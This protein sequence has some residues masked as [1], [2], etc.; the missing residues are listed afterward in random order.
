MGW[1]FIVHGGQGNLLDK[2]IEPLF[3]GG[4]AGR[5]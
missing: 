3:L 1:K 2:G 5:L 4:A